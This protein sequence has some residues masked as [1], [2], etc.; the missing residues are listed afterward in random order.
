MA[1]LKEGDY[2]AGY[3]EAPAYDRPGET[4]IETAPVRRKVRGL[5]G[6]VPGQYTETYLRFTVRGDEVTTAIRRVDRLREGKTPGGFTFGSVMLG[7]SIPLEFPNGTT[8]KIIGRKDGKMI[9]GKSRVRVRY[10]RE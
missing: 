4:V 9:P 7:Y 6:S 10:P 1:K 3:Y 2:G 5:W 8:V